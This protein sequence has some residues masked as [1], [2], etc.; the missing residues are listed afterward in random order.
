[1]SRLDI[2]YQF[3]QNQQQFRLCLSYSPHHQ[4]LCKSLKIACIRRRNILDCQLDNYW[5]LGNNRLLYSNKITFLCHCS[6][7]LDLK[8]RRDF[9]FLSVVAM[10]VPSLIYT[11]SSMSS[12]SLDKFHLLHKGRAE[13]EDTHCQIRGM[14]FHPLHTSC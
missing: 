4:S 12:H 13:K 5:R 3:Y 10:I 1:M 7:Q 11:V 2:L 9:Q 6:K 14:S 8:P